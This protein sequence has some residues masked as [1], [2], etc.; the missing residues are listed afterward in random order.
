MEE[1]NLLLLFI[2]II[3]FSI[4]CLLLLK[5]SLTIPQIL[6]CLFLRE[7]VHLMFYHPSIHASPFYQL[8]CPDANAVFLEGSDTHW[9]SLSEISS[10]SCLESNILFT[11]LT[12]ERRFLWLVHNEKKDTLWTQIYLSILE[13]YQDFEFGNVHLPKILYLTCTL[14]SSLVNLLQF[15]SILFDLN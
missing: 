5:S 8:R 2:C 12:A 15:S 10:M 6:S 4:F 1:F 7:I 13:I 14:V 9:Q 11:F 3:L